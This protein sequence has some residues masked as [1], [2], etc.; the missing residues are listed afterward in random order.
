VLFLTGHGEVRDGVRAIQAGAVDFLTKPVDAATLL[1]AVSRA[2]ARDASAR[3]EQGE[4]AAL[5][6]R[7]ARL[8]PRELEVC[9]LIPTGLTSKEIGVRLG[10]A[11]KT[12]KVH[13]GRVMRKLGVGSVAELTRLVDHLGDLGGPPV[14]GDPEA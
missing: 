7:F 3:A 10:A 14:A 11:E 5:R 2:L 13:R 9:L 1:D 4:L 8:T 6:A 12:V